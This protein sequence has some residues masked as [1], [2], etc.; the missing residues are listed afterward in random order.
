MTNNVRSCL[1]ASAAV[2]ALGAGAQAQQAN[3]TFFVTSAGSGNGANLGGIAGADKHCQDLA[4][5]AGA[6]GHTWHAYLSTQGDGAVNAR[7]RIGSGPWKN[8]KGDVVAKSVDDL[9]S[10]GNN[11]TK[12]TALNEKGGVVNGRGDTPNMHDAL[13]GSQPNGT[14]FAEGEDKTCKNWTS[15]ADGAGA[16]QLGHFDRTGGGNTSW[17]SAHPSRGCSQPN[18]IATG[19][20]G[21]FYCFA[22]N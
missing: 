21:Y 13:T 20:N 11:L 19:G 14:A 22:V 17:N 6:G 3:M 15:G 5:A 9:H 4:T 8:A 12:Q 2:L 7:D 1:F 18:L 16:A 10:A